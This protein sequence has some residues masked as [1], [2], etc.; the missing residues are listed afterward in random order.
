MKRL[1]ALAIYR[2]PL[3]G[4]TVIWPGR[5]VTLPITMLFGPWFGMLAATIPLWS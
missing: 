5:I 2:A 4:L 3:G 1:V